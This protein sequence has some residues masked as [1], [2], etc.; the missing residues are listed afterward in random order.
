M[1][2][3]RKY[4]HGP[5]TIRTIRHKLRYAREMIANTGS[6]RTKSGRIITRLGN[7]QGAAH[8]KGRGNAEA[9]AALRKS[10]D[11]FALQVAPILD[12]IHRTWEGP[13][14][15]TLRELA[16]ELSLRD[17]PTRSG[18]VWEWKHPMVARVLRRI[19]RLTQS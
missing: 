3:R 2:R 4:R 12:E 15:P 17:V 9:V 10:A 8:L 14:P 1:P 13:K 11:A 6:Y 16:V 18:T 5:E 19:E 7:P